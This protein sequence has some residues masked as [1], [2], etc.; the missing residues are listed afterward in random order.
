MSV[1]VAE[2]PAFAIPKAVFQTQ[3]LGQSAVYR[4]SYTPADNG[5]RFL[6][7]SPRGEDSAGEITVT[8]NWLAGLRK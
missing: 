7:N 8:L 4:T 2:G 6:I 1:S 3:V 5:Q